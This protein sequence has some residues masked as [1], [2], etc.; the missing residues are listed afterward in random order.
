MN[1]SLLSLFARTGL[2]S[3]DVVDEAVEGA[4][5]VRGVCPIHVGADNPTAFA[6]KTNYWI[7]NTE[8]CEQD[9]GP[10]LEGLVVALAHRYGDKQLRSRRPRELPFRLA[11]SWLRQNA[12]K[13][14]NEV[15]ADWE[16]SVRH[17]GGAPSGWYSRFP[18][19][20]LCIIQKMRIPSWY[21]QSRGFDLETLRTYDI[22]HPLGGCG[23]FF[24]GL[25]TWAIVPMYEL[26]D[27]TVCVG[28]VARDPVAC[29]GQRW[30]FSPGFPSDQR[31]FNYRRALEANKET[32]RLLLVEGVPDALRCIEAGFPDTVALLGSALYDE[33]VDRLRKMRLDKV[34]VLADND[35]AGNR[36][37]AQAEKIFPAQV[38]KPHPNVKD[39][40]ELNS[41]QA[42]QFL[43]SG[44]AE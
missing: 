41:E 42:R 27:P 18:C 43:V 24:G 16:R 32:G 10:R 33:Q 6:L 29:I 37:S 9:Y 14:R 28:Y 12:N 25:A 20:R 35:E 17:H 39:I 22:G 30:K 7:C 13:L 4:Q 38:I 26:A 40:A 19:S 2:I 23:H 3:P 31:L 36:L 8:H 34:V 5:L 21:F 11:L 1:K 15:F 44:L